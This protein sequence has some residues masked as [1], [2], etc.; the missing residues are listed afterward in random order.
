MIGSRAK[1]SHPKVAIARERIYH[2]LVPTRMDTL[3][4]E[5]FSSVPGT[6]GQDQE[7][8]VKQAE[9][10]LQGRRAGE[11]DFRPS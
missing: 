2:S 5:H 7:L 6:A 4:T 11:I 8:Q 9:L 1:S 10:T 3:D